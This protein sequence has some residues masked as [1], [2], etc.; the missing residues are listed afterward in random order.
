MPPS[1]KPRPFLSFVALLA[2]ALSLLAPPARAGR[3]DVRFDFA[4]AHPFAG[5]GAQ[6]WANTKRP[7]EAMAM[8]RDINARFVRVSL[9]PEIPEEQLGTGMSVEQISALIDR[10]D[11]D[12]QRRNFTEFR[13]RMAAQRIQVVA[14]VWRMPRPWM[15]VR[16]KK[17]GPRKEAGFADPARIPDY[18]NYVTAQMLYLRRLGIQPAAVEL[19]NEPQ[20]AWD[21]KYE[22]RDYADL[23]I[24]ARATLDRAGLQAIRIAGPGTGIRNFDDFHAALKASGAIRNIGYVSAHVYQ[25]PA[26]LQDRATPGVA[27]FLGRGSVGPIL[28]TEYG[29]KK[30]FEDPDSD[31]DDN[32]LDVDTHDYA[33]SAAASSLLLIGMGASGLV[34]YQLEDFSWSK[35]PHG[36]LDGNGRRRPVAEALQTVF[37]R[38]PTEGAVAVAGSGA[39]AQVPIVAFRAAGRWVM[40]AVNQ[41]NEPQT[42]TARLEGSAGTA[43]APAAIAGSSAYPAAATTLSGVAFEAGVLRATIAPRAVVAIELR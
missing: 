28:I 35:K 34:Y 41:S 3:V 39:P 19:T 32:D 27:S 12:R 31:V 9:T 26:Q 8:L 36:L 29:V 20:G 24:K 16:E 6:V 4:A 17:K 10:A 25:T 43:G 1:P 11:S 22:P 2:L 7:A 13:D 14:I 38:L 23:V 30:H 42:L 18:A 40:V 37:G 33:M 15:S 21:T 5:G